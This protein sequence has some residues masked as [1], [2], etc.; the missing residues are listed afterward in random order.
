MN[1]YILICCCFLMLFI[2]CSTNTI[3]YRHYETTNYR[4]SNSHIENNEYLSVDGKFYKI[5][6]LPSGLYIICNGGKNI[7]IDYQKRREDIDFYPIHDVQKIYEDDTYIIAITDKE[8]I[9]LGKINPYDIAKLDSLKSD[10]LTLLFDTDFINSDYCN[11]YIQDAL[12]LQDKRINKKY[13]VDFST[14][15]I[16][17]IL[18]IGLYDNKFYFGQ[19]LYSYFILDLNTDELFFFQNKTEYENY[20]RNEIHH[21]VEVLEAKFLYD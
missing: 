5:P 19:T 6:F 2:S 7:S 14:P 10:N 16:N 4:I 15:V 18:R 8:I 1:K 17:G 20:C 21:S 9:S 12:S 3:E 13:K 11:S